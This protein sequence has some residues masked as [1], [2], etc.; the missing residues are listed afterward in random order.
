MT[1][2]LF[3]EPEIAPS[4]PESDDTDPLAPTLEAPYGYT[5]D[6]ETGERRPKKTAGRRPRST[7]AAPRPGVSPSLEELKATKDAAPKAKQPTEDVAPAAPSRKRGRTRPG[8]KM[9]AAAPEPKTP[10]RA[11]PIAKGV[12]RIYRKAGKIIKVWDPQVGAAVISCTQKEDDDD[13]TVG[14]AWEELARVNPRIR[15]FLERIIT[16]GAWGSLVAAHMPIVLAILLKDSVRERLPMGGLMGAFLD[17][18]DDEQQE[19]GG[20]GGLFGDIGPEDAAQMMAMAQN[21]MA[22][23]MANMPRE[24]PA[25]R[26]PMTVVPGQVVGTVF[27][28]AA[29]A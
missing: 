5:I 23:M 16:G 27:D 24:Q 1:A 12:N 6:P 14:E 20:L 9:A 2:N 19:G 21:M 8:P 3:Q 4:G 22:G 25:P 7:P 13:T 26:P 18:D 28:Q 29:G 11:G 10:F 17:R 15:A